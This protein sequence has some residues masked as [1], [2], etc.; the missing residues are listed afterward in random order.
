MA[1]CPKCKSKI[2]F[3][4]ILFAL[5]PI[6]IKCPSCST[7]LTGNILVEIQAFTIFIISLV[8]GAALVSVWEKFDL[9]L[10]AG[11]LLLVGSVLSLVVPNVY[12]TLKYGDFR[13]RG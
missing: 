8:G 2:R 5:C 7:K 11:T 4:T 9:S 13:E 1:A 12:V 3:H 6:W 10:P